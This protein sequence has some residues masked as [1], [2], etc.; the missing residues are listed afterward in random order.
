MDTNR[1]FIY[2]NFIS[3]KACEKILGSLHKDNW[4]NS[5]TVEHTDGTIIETISNHRKSFN[6]YY[7]PDEISGIIS[8]LETKLNKKYGIITSNLE[9]WQI[10]KYYEGD[11]FD[12]HLDCGCWADSYSG[13]RQKTIMIY[14]ESSVKGGETYFR[15]LNKRIK[16][17]TGKLVLWNNLLPN[18]NCN[19]GMIH[20][21]LPVI[22]GEKTI[23][24][25]WER[26]R[27]FIY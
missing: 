26:Q 21:G 14:I 7:I 16:P 13:E 12:F 3:A 24:V 4:V 22:E 19:H 1:V 10:C 20:S 15:A 17:K 11:Y 25:T 8:K 6:H 2:N 5:Q 27:S 9:D 23:L 18:G